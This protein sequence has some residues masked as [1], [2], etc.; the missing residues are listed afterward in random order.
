MLSSAAAIE[1]TRTCNRNSLP[2]RV[3]RNATGLLHYR[4]DFELKWLRIAKRVRLYWLKAFDYELP[5]L[6]GSA[7]EIAAAI[8]AASTFARDASRELDRW[9]ERERVLLQI[10]SPGISR[11]NEKKARAR[12]VNY[13]DITPSAPDPGQPVKRGP[14]RPPK[15]RPI[16]PTSPLEIKSDKL[17][18][19]LP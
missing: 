12:G 4:S 3:A 11:G 19:P 18:C 15:Q 17:T 9:C 8:Q 14:G 2:Q 16:E 6:S 10:Q 7:L 5:K 1:E 13:L